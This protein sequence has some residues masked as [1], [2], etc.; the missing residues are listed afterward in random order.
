MLIAVASALLVI[1][2][3][4]PVGKSNEAAKENALVFPSEELVID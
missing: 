4:F 1:Q 3:A 2:K